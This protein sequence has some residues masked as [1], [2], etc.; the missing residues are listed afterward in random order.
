MGRKSDEDLKEWGGW[1]R[2]PPRRVV[3]QNR[4]KWLRDENDADWEARIGRENP[5]P[6]NSGMNQ[7]GGDKGQLILRDYRDSNS[8]QLA[9]LKNKK[10]LGGN[11]PYGLGQKFVEEHGLEIE[12]NVG[13]D[14]EDRKRRRSGPESK[15][16]MDTDENM[17]LL[18]YMK[19]INNTEAELSILDCAASTSKEMATPV[20]QASQSP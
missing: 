4:S 9:D 5:I 3:N 13:L 14:I 19:G 12:E 11:T 7:G 1:L 16:V 8:L 18:G 17:I 6:H 20:M 10:E 2:A 15:G